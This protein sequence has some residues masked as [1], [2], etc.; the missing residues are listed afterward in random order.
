MSLSPLEII[1]F[2]LSSFFQCGLLEVVTGK[3]KKIVENQKS[4]SDTP[5]WQKFITTIKL[6]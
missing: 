2:H 5:S 4:K 3:E 6:S 1:P